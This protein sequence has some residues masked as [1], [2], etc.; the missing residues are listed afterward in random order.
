MNGRTKPR[1]L[2]IDDSEEIRK[3]VSIALNQK[4]Y[5][6]IDAADGQSGLALAFTSKPDLILLDCTMP[7]MNGFNVLTYLRSHLSTK[8]TG[9]ILLTS[10][11]SV[12]DKVLGLQKGADDYISKPFVPSELFARVEAAL[13]RSKRDLSLDPISS[14]P[15]NHLLR[16]ELSRRLQSQQTFSVCYIDINNFKP[17]ADHY[18]FER[19]SL[20]IEQFA[21][22]IDD[23]VMELEKPNPEAD[24][25]DEDF[26]GHIGGD[27]FL[28][29]LA[30]TRADTICQIMM[31][32]FE[33]A[34]GSFYD[35]A[36]LQRGYIEG[37]DRY[38]TLRRFPPISL[39]VAILDVKPGDFKDRNELSGFIARCKDEVKRSEGKKIK[40]FT[41][42]SP[43]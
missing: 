26:I 28:L 11:N 19:A 32:R 15:G 10:S 6:V 25:E 38:G 31:N 23:V 29:L 4:G 12:E 33:T 36:D 37:L 41:K 5:E 1:I 7:G 35:E 3:I 17:Y 24:S 40:H 18:G 22:L 43:V 30:S 9:V 16:Q 39:S 21:Q 27:D 14:L 34:V 2:I 42:S 13:R 8:Y 20:V